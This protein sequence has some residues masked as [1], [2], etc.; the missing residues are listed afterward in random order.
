VGFL[1]AAV[2]DDGKSILI[3]SIRVRKEYEGRGIYSRLRE[4][5]LK[6]ISHSS[7]RMALVVYTPD[8]Y[9]KLLKTSA[10]LIFERG[11][12]RLTTTKKTLQSLIVSRKLSADIENVDAQYLEGLF[13]IDSASS[14]LFP[15]KRIVV[16]CVPYQLLSTNIK[17]ILQGVFQEMIATAVPYRKHTSMISAVS[18]D[19][20]EA[21]TL[22][23][24]DLFGDIENENILFDHLN[25]QLEKCINNCGEV[26]VLYIT[27]KI[28]QNV[29]SLSRVL[30]K[31]SWKKLSDDVIHGFEIPI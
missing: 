25:V 9:K 27:F 14:H 28:Q 17:R 4:F 24:L 16:N 6:T 2:I 21:G 19:Q 12:M 29:D 11:A 23:N 13:V 3:Q 26:I 31:L 30:S 8:N 18:F 7:G 1:F 20:C 5:C 15:E 10:K 22:V